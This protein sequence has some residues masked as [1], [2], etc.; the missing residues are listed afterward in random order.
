MEKQ[1]QTDQLPKRKE[2]KK[3][4]REEKRKVGRK[5]KKNMGNTER[6]KDRNKAGKQKQIDKL[7]T[8]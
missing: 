8:L 6:D 2:D 7:K 1:S 3:E 5:K 4:E